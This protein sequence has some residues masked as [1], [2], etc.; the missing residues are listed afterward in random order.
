MLGETKKPF[1]LW[2]TLFSIAVGI[3]FYLLPKTPFVIIGSLLL[4]FSLLIH[5]LWNFWWIEKTLLRRIIACVCFVT[6]LILLGYIVWPLSEAKKPLVIQAE[7]PKQPSAKEIAE[8]LA[9]KLP[10]T[11]AQLPSAKKETQ[12]EQGYILGP[13]LEFSGLKAENNGGYSVPIIKVYNTSEFAVSSYHLIGSVFL[14]DLEN[15]LENEEVNNAINRME[16]EAKNVVLV[17]VDQLQIT[18]G[19]GVEL[20]LQNQF[21]DSDI[22]SVNNGS[23]K[24]YIVMLAIYKTPQTPKNRMW[25]TELCSRVTKPWTD[26]QSC[27]SH[28]KYFFSDRSLNKID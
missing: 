14:S 2:L 16:D 17:P 25:V 3:V 20:K 5:P 19:M 21:S 4:I 11:P 28:N 13:R 9:K 8:E 26:F 18:R 10:S 23:K 27:P 22:A 15:N 24:M 12:P 6:A 7:Q 1:N